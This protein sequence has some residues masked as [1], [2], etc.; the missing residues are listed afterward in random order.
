MNFHTKPTT[1]V[2]QV[3]L[4]V[5]DLD[6]SVTFY[7]ELIG[8]KVLDQTEHTA[9]L[10]ADGKTVLLSIEQ[11]E[12]VVQKQQRTTGLFH[13]AILLPQRADLGKVLIHLVQANYPV[14]GAADHLVSEALYLADP[15]GNGIEIYVDRDPSEW[16]W[17][18]NEVLMPSDPLDAESLIAEAQGET[19]NGL[20]QD[21]LMGHIHLHVSELDKNREFYTEGL[22]FKIVSR[23]DTHALFISDGTYHHHIALNVWNGIGAPPAPENSVGL[24]SFSLMFPDEEK[25]SETVKQ[26]KQLGFPVTETNQSVVTSDPSGNKIQLKV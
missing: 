26:L 16:T 6:R 12:D 19:W 1:F 21:T 13:F 17:N 24:K 25:R 23:Y 3:N 7:T 9:Q 20:P 14:Q 18:N 11:P 22:G 15:D 5:L 8:L 10:T 4:K 2:G